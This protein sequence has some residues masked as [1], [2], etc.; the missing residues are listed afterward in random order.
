MDAGRL[1]TDLK[2]ARPPARRDLYAQ[3]AQVYDFFHPDRSGEVDSWAD[4]SAPHGLR[5]LDLMC[6]T[7][8]VGLGLARR[9]FQVVGIDLSPAMLAVA[10]DRLSAA[11][12]FP[13]RSLSVAQGDACR[14]P[15]SDG[16]FDFALV[17][18]SG[19]LNHLGAG[20]AAEALR[21]IRRV[22]RPGGA[23]G[24][25]LVNPYLLEEI[26]PAR[27]FGPLRPTLG[28]SIDR[29]CSGRYDR[30]AGVYHI[31]QA[32]RVA[33]HDEGTRQLEESFS[34]HV[35]EPDRVVD[36]VADAGFRYIRPYG[37][38][39][40]APF[41]RYSPDLLVIAERTMTTAL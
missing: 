22:L 16:T 40:L 7:A 25:E 11:A 8:E 12:D 29:V 5:V 36:M 4:L 20:Q 2:G 41:E 34:L 38:L 24:V 23:L 13:A 27:R 35:W 14:I 28:V 15:A 1:V 9:G 21:E 10:T 39:D 18:G 3:W 32:T 17:G 6:G 31:H 26:A 30:V 19:S 37:G 33:S